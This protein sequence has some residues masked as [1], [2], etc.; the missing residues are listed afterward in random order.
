MLWAYRTGVRTTT[1]ET[2]FNLV[3]G[4]SAVILTEVSIETHRILNYDEEQNSQLMRENLDL[5]EEV[6][7]N[8]KNR[9]KRYKR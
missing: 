2:P 3:Y 4:A 1:G 7:S 8:A 6:R 5:I 9:A